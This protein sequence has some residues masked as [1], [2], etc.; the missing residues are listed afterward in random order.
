MKVLIFG[1]SGQTGRILMER[2]VSDGH[3][4]TVFVRDPGRLK[5][6]SESVRVVQGDVLDAAAVDRAVA[7]QQ[8]VLVALGSAS[9]G[10][11]PVLPQGIGHILD[12]MERYRVRRIIVLSAAGAL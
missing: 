10:F 2:T 8:A 9:R 7:G 1:A 4:V 5:V 12:A 6:P 11:P 3:Q